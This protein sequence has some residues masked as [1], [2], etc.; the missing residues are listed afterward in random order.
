MFC[1]AADISATVHATDRTEIL[2]DGTNGS[3]LGRYP[4]RIPEIPKFWPSKNLISQ[5]R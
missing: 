2:Q 4:L 3:R 1:L 5:K